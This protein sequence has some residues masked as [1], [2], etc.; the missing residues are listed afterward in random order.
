MSRTALD[1][2]MLSALAAAHVTSFLLLELGFDSGTQYLTSA[3]HNVP[4]DGH[5]YLAAQG[6]GSIEPII[7]TD[8]EARGL[9]FT[10]SAVAQSAI[11]GALTEDIQGRPVLLRMAVVD[12]GALLVDPN[13]WSGRFDAMTIE[14]GPSGPVIR[15]TAE[16]AMIAWQQPSGQLFSDQ[17]QQAI[18]PGDLFF[19]HAAKM[20]EATIVWPAKSFF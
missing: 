3:P 12:A 16:H 18:A 17:D 9:S 20:A 7:E 10:L 11:A 13:V 8:S 5:D 6:I 2:S 14:D 19:Q 15:A 1:P 4:W